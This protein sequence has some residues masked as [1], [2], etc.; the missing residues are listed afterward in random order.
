[1]N[2]SK[3]TNTNQL[4]NSSIYRNKSRN[5]TCDKNKLNIELID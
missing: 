3:V 5:T 4:K 2:S 1:M